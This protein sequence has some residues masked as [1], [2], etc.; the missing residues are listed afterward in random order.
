MWKVSEE[1]LK[2]GEAKWHFRGCAGKPHKPESAGPSQLCLASCE[3]HPANGKENAMLAWIFW[4]LYLSREDKNCCFV[5]SDPWSLIIS[6]SWSNWYQINHL[7]ILQHY[8]WISASFLILDRKNWPYWYELETTPVKVPATAGIT[9]IL[10]Q[11]NSCWSFR[12]FSQYSAGPTASR[13][14]SDSL[15]KC[16]LTFPE[17]GF[18]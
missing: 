17:Q 10:M 5:L 15:A 12:G 8:F 2:V 6:F 14:W 3:E 13:S 11:F 18:C 7:L 4:Q 1:K 16:S 9:S